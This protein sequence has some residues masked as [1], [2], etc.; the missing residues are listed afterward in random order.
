LEQLIALFLPLSILVR[1]P[2]SDKAELLVIALILPAAILAAG[3]FLLGPQHVI[4]AA[5]GSEWLDLLSLGAGLPIISH[6]MTRGFQIGR[7]F[8]AG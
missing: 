7:A 1:I 3:F 8:A 2:V 4:A 6:L 5:F